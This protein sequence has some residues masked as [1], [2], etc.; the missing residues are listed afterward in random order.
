MNKKEIIL[1]THIT[2]P[3][4]G[5]LQTEIMPEGECVQFWECPACKAKWM[6][7]NDDCCVYCSYADIPCPSAQK[8][9]E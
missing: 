6:P 4:C 3:G 7:E 1:I 9:V 5:A 8:G 2:C